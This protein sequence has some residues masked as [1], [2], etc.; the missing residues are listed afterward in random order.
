VGN[1]LTVVGVALQLAGAFV[2]LHGLVKTHDAYAEKSIRVIVS[3]RLTLVR[4]RVQALI[5]RLRRKPAHTEAMAGTA[6][7]GGGAFGAMA[8]ITWAPIPAG[9]PTADAIK[10]LDRRVRDLLGR[11]L[12]LDQVVKESSNQ[13]RDALEALRRDLEQADRN[14]AQLVR[15][16]AIDGLM[17]EAIGLIVVSVGAI[18][19]SGTHVGLSGA[20][21]YL[22]PEVSG[23][24]TPSRER[25][26]MRPAGCAADV[27]SPEPVK[28]AA[29]GARGGPG[30]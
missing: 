8:M 21:A 25:I 20:E 7:G 29:V 2:V 12:T 18:L 4:V 19:Q 6:H 16:A 11:V 3:E 13:S 14:A 30:R 22:S 10:E 26:R 5:D 17:R 15:Q 1:V 24:V 27:A 9:T 23:R 28:S